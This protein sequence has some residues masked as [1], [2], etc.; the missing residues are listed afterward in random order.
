MD[1]NTSLDDLRRTLALYGW[2]EDF[3]PERDNSLLVSLIDVAKIEPN[4]I[5][6]FLP[7]ANTTRQ[8]TVSKKKTVERIINDFGPFRLIV[9]ER[10]LNNDF[11]ESQNSLDFDLD[12][13]E[14]FINNDVDQFGEKE[15]VLALMAILE[16]F[17]PRYGFAD[18]FDRVAAS[19]LPSGIGSSEMSRLDNLRA[20]D[21]FHS[22]HRTREH[23]NGKMHDVYALN[24]LS[25]AHMNWPVGDK[26]LREWINAGNRGE[27]FDTK[28]GLTLWAVEDEIKA[29]VR[30]EL[31]KKGCLIASV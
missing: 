11:R 6:F 20:A 18:V 19:S 9:A 13:R 28:P 8:R 21:L 31:F 14:L 2:S 5:T 22:R 7:G 17:T 25:D 3:V 12:R 1:E 29:T 10:I 4:K 15:T 24:I 16:V 26:S 27:L 30:H 23:V